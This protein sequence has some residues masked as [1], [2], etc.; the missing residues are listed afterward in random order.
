MGKLETWMISD[1][2]VAIVNENMVGLDQSRRNQVEGGIIV[3]SSKT[4][5]VIK[6][7]DEWFASR[8]QQ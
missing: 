3:S 2:M 4:L 1:D 5:C 6:I 7:F 8:T